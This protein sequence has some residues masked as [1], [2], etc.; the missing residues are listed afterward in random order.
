M[1]AAP[2]RPRLAQQALATG[3]SLPAASLALATASRR[4][5]SSVKKPTLEE[6]CAMPTEYSAM[7]NDLLCMMST[8]DPGALRE[9]VIREVMSVDMS[10]Y[11]DAEK[12]VTKIE[13]SAEASSIA[14]APYYTGIISA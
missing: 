4:W 7:S 6:A 3:R 9:R 12:M 10:E 1:L 8:N 2:R 13:E 14:R 5:F 11:D